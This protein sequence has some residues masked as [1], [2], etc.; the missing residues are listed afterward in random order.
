MTKAVFWDRDGVLNHDP[1]Y[2]VQPEETAFMAGAAEAVAMAT[3]AGFLNLIV[4]NQAGIA[5]GYYD[6]AAFHRY[7]DWFRG[8]LSTAGG[9]IDAVYFCPYHPTEGIGPYRRDSPDRKPAPGMILGAVDAHGLDPR[10]CILIGDNRS[11]LAAAAAAGVPGHLFPG[12][13]LAAFLRG[14]LQ[15]G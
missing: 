7:M 12:G 13:D 11:D 10:R 9:R 15:D 5:R 1:G 3:A 6:E 8:A 14:I 2:L 4:T